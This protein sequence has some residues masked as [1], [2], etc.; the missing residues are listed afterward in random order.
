M[1]Q[2]RN[3]DAVVIKPTDG[4][5]RGYMEGKRIGEPN[6]KMLNYMLSERR[7]AMQGQREDENRW[8]SAFNNLLSTVRADK[9]N[10]LYASQIN[11]L[12]EQSVDMAM[13]DR[14]SGNMNPML[15]KELAANIATSEKKNEA[16]TAI[17]DKIHKEAY[18]DPYI[19]KEKFNKWYMS[20]YL[21]ETDKNGDPILTKDAFGNEVPKLK[22]LSQISS[23]DI[24]SLQNYDFGNKHGFSSVFDQNK[25]WSSLAKSLPDITRATGNTQG[26]VLSNSKTGFYSKIKEGYVY[27]PVSGEAVPKG[28]PVT[29]TPAEQNE[30]TQK[31]GIGGKNIRGVSDDVYHLAITDPYTLQYLNAKIN[32]MNRDLGYKKG[33]PNYI[34]PGSEQAQNIE[35]VFIY[36]G[37][38]LHSPATVKTTTSHTLTAA[39][40]FFADPSAWEKENDMKQKAK[41]DEMSQ[42]LATGIKAATS[43]ND[44]LIQQ[45]FGVEPMTPPLDAGKMGDFFSKGNVYDLGQSFGIFKGYKD[46]VSNENTP[47]THVYV[48]SS[49]PNTIYVETKEDKEPEKITG[50]DN[51]NKLIRQMTYMN[52]GKTTF[53]N[54]IKQAGT[55]VRNYL[56]NII[57]QGNGS[58][59][60]KPKAQVETKEKTASKEKGEKNKEDI[61]NF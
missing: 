24:E 32:D 23:D 1:P 6:Y 21:A 8:S 11:D 49:E 46:E 22:P 56:T 52:F 57:P 16:L 2:V 20:S 40:R 9:A 13:K 34:I 45:T 15:I 50:K 30:F 44:E 5:M 48:N 26:G 59:D 33:D 17:T 54:Y 27:D 51:I 37:L 42:Y 12:A 55:K 31:M 58:G 7:L 3:T 19:D 61:P 41:G 36:N 53:G 4:F 43:G 35:K 18:S 39:G 38:R 14:L 25:M 47:F 10:T 28:S 60:Q 29:L